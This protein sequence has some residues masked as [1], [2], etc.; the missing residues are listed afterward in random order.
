MKNTYVKDKDTEPLFA[1]KI[2]EEGEL[3]HYK[4]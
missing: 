2:L 4:N 1:N 3:F